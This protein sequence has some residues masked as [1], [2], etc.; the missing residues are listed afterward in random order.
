MCYWKQWRQ[1]RTRVGNLLRL[2]TPL[3]QSVS[4]GSS[5]KG[6]WRLSKTLGTQ[7]GMTNQWLET[8]GLISLKELWVN[9]HY[10]I[11]VR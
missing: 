3:Q 7:A 11:K 4:T 5:G 2:K 9:I 1:V 6:Y 8:Q 10:P